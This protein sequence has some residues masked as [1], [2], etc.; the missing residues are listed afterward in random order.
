MKFPVFIFVF[1]LLFVI[2]WGFAFYYI[3][4]RF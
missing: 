3:S 1:I 4:T 2:V